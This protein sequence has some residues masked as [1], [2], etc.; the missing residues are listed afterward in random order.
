[1]KKSNTIIILN[2]L[3][4]VIIQGLNFLASPIFSRLLGTENYGVVSL[5]NTWTMIITAVFSLQ[6][7]S[8]LQIARNRFPLEDQD[9]YQSSVLSFGS[10][11]YLLF[12]LLVL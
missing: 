11:N 4:T 8:T 9:K 2:I 10:V 7:G 3:S 5:Y 6:V 1:M 12:S